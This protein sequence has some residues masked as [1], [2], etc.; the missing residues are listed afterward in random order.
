MSRGAMNPTSVRRTVPLLERGL[1]RQVTAIVRP[2]GKRRI[3]V[4]GRRVR[5]RRRNEIIRQLVAGGILEAR[6]KR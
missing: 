1:T 4:D 6:S 5:G 2:N 3:E